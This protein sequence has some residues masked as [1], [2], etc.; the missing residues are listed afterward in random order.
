MVGS[1]AGQMVADVRL[2]V[3][4]RCPVAFH[5]RTGDI[6]PAPN[7]VTEALR[8]PNS[9][10]GGGWACEMAARLVD[11]AAPYEARPG[12]GAVTTVFLPARLAA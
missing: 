6:V 12:P 7:Q 1:S 5:G 8:A 10:P 9:G 2:A 4:G 3:E 11:L